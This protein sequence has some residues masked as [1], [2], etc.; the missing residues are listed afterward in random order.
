MK[1]L[2]KTILTL[3][4]VVGCLSSALAVNAMPTVPKVAIL[5][6]SNTVPTA[7]T[8][9]SG[10]ELDSLATEGWTSF[11]AGT[12]ALSS[13]KF[14]GGAWSVSFTASSNYAYVYA[15]GTC[16]RTSFYIYCDAYPSAKAAF[17]N[18][19]NAGGL[20]LDTTGHL[21]MYNSSGMEVA[22]SSNTVGLGAW[23]RISVSLTAANNGLAWIDGIAA[24]TSTAVG[25][26]ILAAQ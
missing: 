13:A 23:H 22:T 1:R 8:F 17:F 21:V 24:I 25:K 14:K 4:L 9:F 20:K 7:L 2:L 15:A 10:F 26:A 3:G 19:G 12:T 16:N 11:G 18:G 6:G 5:N